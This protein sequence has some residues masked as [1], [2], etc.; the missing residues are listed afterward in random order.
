MRR[1]DSVE[2]SAR[3]EDAD[4][5]IHL[6]IL[7]PPLSQLSPISIM[8]EPGSPATQLFGLC[9]FSSRTTGIAGDICDA[10]QDIP[11]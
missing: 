7:N 6:H 9:D 8:P 11:H 10:L 1:V 3:V 2:Q 5:M 4:E